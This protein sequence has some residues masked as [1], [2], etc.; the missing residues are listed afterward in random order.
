MLLLLLAMMRVGKEI[1]EQ[2]E[3]P[4]EVELQN[5]RRDNRERNRRITEQIL[6]STTSLA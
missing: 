6:I 1:G 3:E 5:H 2:T 4:E